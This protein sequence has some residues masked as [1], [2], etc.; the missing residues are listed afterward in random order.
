MRRQFQYSIPTFK[1]SNKI[2]V[3]NLDVKFRVDGSVES[4]K[5]NKSRLV[6]NQEEENRILDEI[7]RYSGLEYLDTEARIDLDN[8]RNFQFKSIL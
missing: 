4:F 1:F 3:R 7:G 5:V 6:Y 8:I 2:D